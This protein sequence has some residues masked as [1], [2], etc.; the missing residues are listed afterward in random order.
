MVGA[1]QNRTIRQ[2]RADGGHRGE[3]EGLHGFD[4]V[5]EMIRLLKCLLWQL[6]CRQGQ[7][8]VATRSQSRPA[9]VTYRG[10][11]HRAVVGGAIEYRLSLVRIGKLECPKV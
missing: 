10:G 6:R 9:G 5:L 4:R 3:G 7:I 2:D 11:R 1:E 8:P